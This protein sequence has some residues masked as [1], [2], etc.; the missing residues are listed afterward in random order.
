ME[1]ALW[2]KIN[3]SRTISSTVL[4][5]VLMEYALWESLKKQKENKLWS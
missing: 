5:L 3:S 1:Y 4:I 2:D